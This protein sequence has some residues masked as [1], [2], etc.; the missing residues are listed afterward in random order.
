M[1]RSLAF[2]FTLFFLLTAPSQ[3]AAK[4]ATSKITIEGADIAKPI[5]ITDQKVL[6]NFNIWTGPGRSSTKPGSNANA[7]GLI[8]DWSQGSVAEPPKEAR[9][10]KVSFYAG[11]PPNQRIVYVVYYAVSTGNAQGYVY[12]PGKSDEFYRLNTW[13]I[14]RGQEGNWFPAWSV[15]ETVARPLIDK[16]MAEPRKD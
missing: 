5:E 11:D 2:P 1:K 4:A 16:A 6:A 15:W 8:I 7:P 13:S 14:W 9:R 12:L 3:L 10:Y